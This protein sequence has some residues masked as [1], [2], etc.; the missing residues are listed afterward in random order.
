MTWETYYDFVWMWHGF[1]IC[2][3][4]QVPV[5]PWPYRPARHLEW[6]VSEQGMPYIYMERQQ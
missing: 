4:G 2:Y 5:H 1:R 6:A 3:P